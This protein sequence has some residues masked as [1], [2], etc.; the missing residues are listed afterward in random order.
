M[1][2]ENYFLALIGGKLSIEGHCYHNLLYRD[3][4]NQYIIRYTR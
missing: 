1:V 2:V 3:I 4:N